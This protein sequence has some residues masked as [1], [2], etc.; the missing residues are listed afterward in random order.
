[1]VENS[2]GRLVRYDYMTF[3]KDGKR[4]VEGDN[5]MSFGKT[6]MAS[7][8]HLPADKEF[9]VRFH[10]GSD[11][12]AVVDADSDRNGR[13]VDTYGGDLG[14]RHVHRSAHSAMRAVRGPK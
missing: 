7:F 4:T 8:K 2:R 5:P 3:D 12:K 6:G 1:M 14:G 9:T 10:A 11:R 13:D